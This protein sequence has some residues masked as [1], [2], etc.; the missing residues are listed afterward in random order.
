MQSAPVDRAEIETNL[1]T[2]LIVAQKTLRLRQLDEK[3]KLELQIFWGKNKPPFIHSDHEPSFYFSRPIA[4]PN[5]ETA[6]FVDICKHHQA[7][8]TLLEFPGKFV[9]RN[10]EQMH[11]VQLRVRD[12]KKPTVKYKISLI[13]INQWSGKPF[14]S[15]Y[16]QMGVSLRDFHHHFFWRKYSEVPIKVVEITDWFMSSRWAYKHYY[17][18]F[19]SIFIVEGILMENYLLDDPGEYIFFQERVYPSFLE[20]ESI[21]GI[22]PLIVSLLPF[23]TEAKTSWLEYCSDDL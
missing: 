19:L 18:S 11:S 16:T 4:T 8:A 9:S 20:L 6:L 3:L 1:Y 5:Y 21:F 14:E 15:I 13:D 23:E 22:K 2:D 10:R 7:R 12:S 17:M